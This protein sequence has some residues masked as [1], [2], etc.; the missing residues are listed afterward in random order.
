MVVDIFV[1]CDGNGTNLVIKS[2]IEV[3]Y[4]FDW[5]SSNYK[6]L[7]FIGR[8]AAEIFI[9][10][11]DQSIKSM[12]IQRHGKDLYWKCTMSSLCPFSIV[13]KSQDLC[14]SENSGRY[15]ITRFSLH[16]HSSE[17]IP[18]RRLSKNEEKIIIL[19]RDL[20]NLKLR[21]D[22]YREKIKTLKNK[23]S[24]N[25]YNGKIKWNL[26]CIK[27]KEELL[28]QYL[29]LPAIESEFFNTYHFHGYNEGNEIAYHNAIQKLQTCS[30]LA[31]K[32]I[33]LDLLTIKM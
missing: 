28:K 21:I 25:K 30:K 8:H 17:T 32:N 1:S 27:K 23:A 3:Q 31:I 2:K 15:V 9:D 4:A 20:H 5:L 10:K 6:R 7:G 26:Q 22:E 33:L 14:A 29:D 11:C 13:I 19:K 12:R 18:D 16:N 24:I